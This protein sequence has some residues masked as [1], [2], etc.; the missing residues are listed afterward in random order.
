MKSW[1][2]LPSTI[3]L[4]LA[5]VL[6]LGS[7]LLGW[8]P[9]TL[10][11]LAHWGMLIGGGLTSLVL[12]KT[13]ETG[14]MKWISI[15]SCAAF[16]GFALFALFGATSVAKYLLLLPPVVFAIKSFKGGQIYLFDPVLLLLTFLLLQYHMQ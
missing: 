16:T 15:A 4:V 12:F 7:K 8:D 13:S 5:A 11:P 10:L 9:R 2:D 6:L 1:S 14:L 3:L